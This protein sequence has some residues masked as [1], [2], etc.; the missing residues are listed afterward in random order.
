DGMQRAGE[1]ERRL[2]VGG[3]R[4]AW[5]GAAGKP[6]RVE[7]D[8]CGDR[9]LVSGDEPAVD[10]QLCPA[11]RPFAAGDVG[12][13]GGLELKTQLV[14]PCRQRVWCGDLVGR[15]ADVVV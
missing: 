9:E 8:R 10:V 14:P 2:V 12:L 3:D 1:A 11:E 15:T 4:R 6:A 5:V 7:C 13:A